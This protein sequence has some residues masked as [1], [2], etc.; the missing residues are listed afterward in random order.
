MP[1]SAPRCSVERRHKPAQQSPSS[2]LLSLSHPSE[3]ALIPH[4]KKHTSLLGTVSYLD[5][6]FC[7]TNILRVHVPGPLV[8]VAAR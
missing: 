2:F 6:Q 5:R 4:A 8:A 3:R 1:P 7:P